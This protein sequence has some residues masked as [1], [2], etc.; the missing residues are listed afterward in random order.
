MPVRSLAP[1]ALLLP[2]AVAAHPAESGF[3][4]AHFEHVL[5]TS[6]TVKL[7]A[8]SL[9]A[10]R[11]AERVAL[12]EIT[13]LEATLSGHRPDSE[14]GRWLSAPLGEVRVVSDDLFT[15]LSHFDHWREQTA[16]AL[17][18][19][20]EHL[21]HLWQA[22]A[23][24][25]QS[26]TE[27]DRF[28]AVAAVGQTHWRLDAEARTATRLTAV[29]LRLH[30][31]AKSYVLDRAADAALA[32]PGVDGLVLNGG[33]DLLVRGTWRETVA[34]ANPRAPA[35]N[36]A[37]IARIAVQNAAVATS[38]AYRRGLRV[39]AEWVSHLFDPRT[40]L[41]ARAIASATVLHP[42]ALTAGA[43]AT[44]FAVLTP[45]E[46]AALA[47][48]QPGAEYL[49]VPRDGQPLTSPGWP[50]LAPP[51]SENK[52]TPTRA[53][54]L[55]VRKEKPWNPNQELLITLEL[56]RFEGRSHRPFV[57]VWIE[58]EAGKPVRQ[59]ALWYNKPRWL[60]ELREWYNL[61][62]DDAA[63]SVTSATRSPGQYT[64]V[65]DGKD[66]QGRFVRQGNYAVVIE[67]AREHGTYQLIR[68]V[69]DFNGKPKQQALNGNVEISTA[70]LDYRE[71]GTAR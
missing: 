55:S 66:D 48:R 31:F 18:P 32:V 36:A 62:A 1:F 41:P 44:A 42:D 50:G 68:Q 3:Y 5:G 24:A 60:R 8:S 47:A 34:V 20:A 59:V 15:V 63:T 4:I 65:W 46:S 38:G 21:A 23:P 16:G 53:Y 37:P 26:P 6:L 13:R 33:G 39:G 52:P 25:G 19:A 69:M 43:L 49:L 10:A 71:K 29:P 2:G 7:A 61:R 28:G 12:A 22:T 70:A 57:A 27:A 14:F 9:A 64:L 35:E 58:D 51:L 17:N 67:A 45:D 40:G 54:L 56:P 11:R 30:S